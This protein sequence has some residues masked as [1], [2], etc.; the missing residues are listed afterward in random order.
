MTIFY[1]ISILIGL[2]AAIGISGNLNRIANAY[3]PDDAPL[4]HGSFRQGEE[5]LF[6]LKGGPMDGTAIVMVIDEF[7]ADGSVI[8]SPAQKED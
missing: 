7:T 2:F 5:V 4:P 8:C 3:D 1:I 6:N